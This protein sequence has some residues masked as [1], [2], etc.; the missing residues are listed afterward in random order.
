MTYVL[1][2]QEE[3]G[4][5]GSKPANTPIEL[6]HCLQEPI[7]EDY[8]DKKRYQKLVGKLIYLSL[9]RPDIAY[10]VHVVSQ[11][12][13]PPKIPHMK[14]VERILRYLKTCPGK[15]VLF[16][17]H[18]KIEIKAY[19]DANWARSIGDRKTTSGYCTFVG[20]NLVTWRSKKQNVV[21]RSIAEVEYRVMAHGV[22]ELLWLRTLL[23]AIVCGACLMNYE[24]QGERR[25]PPHVSGLSLIDED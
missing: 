17:K 9:T 15:G 24:A 22:A 18:N 12:M 7:G 19:T 21:A 14:V 8:P 23:G 20:G 10:A 2:L 1:D 16:K 5:M 11:F 4:M 13:H 25:M 6:N 3:T